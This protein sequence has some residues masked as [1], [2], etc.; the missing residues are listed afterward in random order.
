MSSS[1]D[2]RSLCTETMSTRFLL[3]DEYSSAVRVLSL[4]KLGLVFAL[5]LPA[6]Y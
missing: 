6:D 4:S 2:M 3:N 1:E 5:Q